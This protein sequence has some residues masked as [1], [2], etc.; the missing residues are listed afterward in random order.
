MFP[1][2]HTI[3]R[4]LASRTTTPA[5]VTNHLVRC[6]RSVII[7]PYVVFRASLLGRRTYLNARY[8]ISQVPTLKIATPW[9]GV[10]LGLQSAELRN[11]KANIFTTGFS[12]ATPLKRHM[13]NSGRLVMIHLLPQR[14][15]RWIPDCGL[16]QMVQWSS[17]AIPLKPNIPGNSCPRMA[18]SQH[19]ICRS[20]QSHHRRATPRV[21]RLNSWPIFSP[22]SHCAS[23]LRS[24]RV[25]RKSSLL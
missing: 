8:S 16:R 18:L 13:A 20:E 3:R 7:P 10:R 25:R 19:R 4:A 1:P 14:P 23:C 2:G 5:T 21:Q 15:P 12:G 9:I 11:R 17:I 6:S 22:R 24:A